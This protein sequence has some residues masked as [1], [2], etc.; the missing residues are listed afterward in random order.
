MWFPVSVLLSNLAPLFPEIVDIRFSKIII[1]VLSLI[2]EYLQLIPTLEID[3]K[4]N[5]R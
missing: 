2:G 4:G 1:L 5:I 3:N